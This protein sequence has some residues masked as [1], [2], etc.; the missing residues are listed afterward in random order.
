MVSAVRD[1]LRKRRK[2]DW[3]F[4][5]SAHTGCRWADRS[6]QMV[7]PSRLPSG[8]ASASSAQGSSPR[9]VTHLL[10]ECPIRSPERFTAMA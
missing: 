3:I 5:C 7:Q 10:A 1:L 8:G 6:V 2:R 9:E 4:F